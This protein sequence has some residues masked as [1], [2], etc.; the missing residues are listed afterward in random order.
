M[1]RAYAG[2]AALVAALASLPA[3]AHQQVMV[4]I[5]SSYPKNYKGQL[6]SELE[7]DERGRVL[8][9]GFKDTIDTNL[10]YS[11]EDIHRGVV[12]LRALNKDI[13]HVRGPSFEATSGGDLLLTFYRKFLSGDDRRQIRFT[14]TRTGVGGTWEARTNDAQGREIFDGISIQMSMAIG[15]PSGVSEIRLTRGGQVVRRYK[16][17]DL[18]RPGTRLR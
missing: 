9:F 5:N 3:L 8:E 14:Y 12:L 13:I 10:K 7:T 4:Q 6:T 16:T 18:P 11:V 1:N 17:E 2:I 15:V